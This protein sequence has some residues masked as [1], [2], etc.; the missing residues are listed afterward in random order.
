MATK[1]KP[2]T[3]KIVS[4]KSKIKIPQVKLNA[5]AKKLFVQIEKD[6]AKRIIANAKIDSKRNYSTDSAK[7]LW[8]KIA[9]AL[10]QKTISAELKKATKSNAFNR[11]EWCKKNNAVMVDA[12]LVVET[13]EKKDAR[14]DNAIRIRISRLSIENKIG[15]VRV[16]S[17][18]EYL[19]EINPKLNNMVFIYKK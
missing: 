12:S 15:Y 3:K 16:L 19:D 2:K 8:Q 17:N 11:R 9:V 10:T 5:N 7:Y 14:V 6:V 1:R 13:K 18:R 4:A